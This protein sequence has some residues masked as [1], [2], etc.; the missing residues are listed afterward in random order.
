MQ[1]TT[2]PDID[3]TLSWAI[4][5]TMDQV[6]VVPRSQRAGPYR[7]RMTHLSV[8]IGRSRSQITVPVWQQLNEKTFPTG[9]SALRSSAV[10]NMAA[11][12]TDAL[13][14]NAK[15]GTGPRFRDAA[16][17]ARSVELTLLQAPRMAVVPD[18]L[19]RPIHG[20]PSGEP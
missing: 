14:P 13:L 5:A 16:H 7:P 8:S 15:S 17:A 19:H 18:I 2:A 9:R 10:I 1:P 3:S 11:G 6:K 12:N 4:E 20:F